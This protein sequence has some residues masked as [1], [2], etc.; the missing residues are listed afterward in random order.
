MPAGSAQPAEMRAR[1]GFLIEMK[2]LRIEARGKRFDLLGRK[3]MAPDRKF[4]PQPEVVEIFHAR[5]VPR[6]DC[7]APLRR[8]NIK[9]LVI[10]ITVVP[11]WLTISNRNLTK[12]I[13]GR[14]REARVSSTLVRTV[15]RSP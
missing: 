7:A 5:S 1:G 4:L 3:Q 14:E 10:V 9:L 6:A 12:P 11:A 8:P 2:P 15:S 13:S